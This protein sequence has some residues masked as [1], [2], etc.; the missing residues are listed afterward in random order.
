MKM[1][2]YIWILCTALLLVIVLVAVMANRPPQL[3]LDT[4]EESVPAFGED[5]ESKDTDETKDTEEKTEKDFR[6][7]VSPANAYLGKELYS[8]ALNS[9]KMSEDKIM[10]LPIFKMETVG[11]LA[12]FQNAFGN[13]LS[14]GSVRE[15]FPAFETVTKKYD[16]AFFEKNTL[17][18]I[19]VTP[20]SGSYR[21]GVK[22]VLS[23]GP[24][25][26]VYAEQTNNPTAVTMDLVGWLI[27]VE[28]PKTATADKTDFDATLTRPQR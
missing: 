12:A 23:H 17:F 22:D 26:T 21:Y 14:E 3:D 1:K 6:F 7:T 11:E 24:N 13:S 25:L 20:D 28:M 10:H 18:V 9:E 15:G 2:K 5:T 27:S 8:S 16:A 4:E 19:Y